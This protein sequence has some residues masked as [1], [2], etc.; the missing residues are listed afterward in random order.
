MKRLITLGVV[1][2]FLFANPQAEQECKDAGGTFVDGV[3]LSQNISSQPSPQEQKRDKI[4]K[5]LAGR[6]IKVNGYFAFYGNWSDNDPDNPYKWVYYASDG[7]FFAK[8]DGMDPNTGYLKWT[9]LNDYFK[10]F[11][12]QNGNIVVGNSAFE[13]ENDAF[14]GLCKQ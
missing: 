6:S 2:V 8:L 10:S 11:S 1:S 7:S 5:E 13:C 4:I 14:P 3:C 12:Y 9:P